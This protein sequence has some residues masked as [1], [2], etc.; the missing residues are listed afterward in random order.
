[1][2][3]CVCVC[4]CSVFLLQKYTFISTYHLYLWYNSV[5]VRAS[6]CWVIHSKLLHNVCFVWSNFNAAIRGEVALATREYEKQKWCGKAAG[7]RDP[8]NDCHEQIW[9]ATGCTTRARTSTHK[10]NTHALINTKANKRIL[11]RSN[12][13]HQGTHQKPKST[14]T[15]TREQWEMI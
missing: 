15:C 1:M 8:C 14:H 3:V 4:P 10:H 13:S 11:K 6:I 5:G 2:C 7:G 9:K 12:G